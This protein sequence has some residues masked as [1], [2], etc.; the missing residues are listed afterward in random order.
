[1]KVLMLECRIWH[2]RM[3]FGVSVLLYAFVKLEVIPHTSTLYNSQFY[4][5]QDKDD[6]NISITKALDKKW[7]H[8]Q[9]L[10]SSCLKEWCQLILLCLFPLDHFFTFSIVTCCNIFSTGLFFFLLQT[11]LYVK[12]CP[13]KAWTLLFSSHITHHT[14]MFVQ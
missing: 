14:P 10:S 12:G 3:C 13:S 5:K 8:L 6:E 1:M 11:G 7:Q 4:M 2:G 9:L